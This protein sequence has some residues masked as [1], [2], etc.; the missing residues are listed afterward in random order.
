M[1]AN[2]LQYDFEWIIENPLVLRLRNINFRSTEA[3]FLINDDHFS[4][5]HLKLSQ[6][7]PGGRDFVC[8]ITYHSN[9]GDPLIA[10]T[11]CWV[12][13]GHQVLHDS[14]KDLEFTPADYYEIPLTVPFVLPC[15]RENALKI[16]CTIRPRN[17][18]EREDELRYELELVRLG[19]RVLSND[20]HDLLL[21]G[22]VPNLKMVSIE[23]KEYSV[24]S[25]ILKKR[26][27]K[28]FANHNIEDMNIQYTI[29]AFISSSVLRTILCFVYCA[30]V[31]YEALKF[32]PQNTELVQSLNYYNLLQLHTVYAHRRTRVT[33]VTKVN[34]VEEMREGKLDYETSIDT[35]DGFH[36]LLTVSEEPSQSI[37]FQIFEEN[38][39]NL[40][41]WLSY[42][43]YMTSATIS[44]ISIE[45]AIT[46]KIDTHH[47]FLYGMQYDLVGSPDGIDGR[48]I[49]FLG[50]RGTFYDLLGADDK[51]NLCIKILY[52]NG[53]A[54]N[55]I[56]D[57]GMN[58]NETES[59]LR[60]D[61]IRTLSDD[62]REMY[63]EGYHA[64]C[65][66]RSSITPQKHAE[67]KYFA[68]Q[69]IL[70]T[71]IDYW[72]DVNKRNFHQP[73][74]R[75]PVQYRAL[76]A[77]LHYVYTGILETHNLEDAVLQAIRVSYKHLRLIELSHYFPAEGQGREYSD[78]RY[79][80][81]VLMPQKSHG[82]ELLKLNTLD[83][84]LE[85][86]E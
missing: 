83:V 22:C 74:C 29:P 35:E 4:R 25:F 67:Q 13:F 21:K 17:I 65:E 52:S 10:D 82:V 76:P 33:Q 15:H 86:E 78:Q 28:L 5:F 30:R 8:V 43:I 49:L 3:N 24:N 77:I 31:E 32:S 34:V 62:M 2:N 44:P 84:V 11:W 9:R 71:R 40:G 45:V 79:L 42:R 18:G 51:L 16:K 7:R 56:L 14:R 54:S 53:R 41:R 75:L 37:Y 70:L 66:V 63:R 26:W 23:G 38:L 68:H 39:G 48:C 64:N 47:T 85:F 6:R 12:L 58:I 73:I 20:M 57:D 36:F 1:A 61:L 60:Y 81:L 69:P 55:M 46:A 19:L 72:E 50:S 59:D 80:C 27:S